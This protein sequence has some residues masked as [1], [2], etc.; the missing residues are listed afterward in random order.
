MQVFRDSTS[1]YQ[2]I[3]LDAQTSA[4]Y[5]NLK[6]VKNTI[7]R[8]DAENKRLGG[9]LYNDD[10]LNYLVEKGWFTAGQLEAAKNFRTQILN[11]RTELA[12]REVELTQQ[13][14]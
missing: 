8:L 3:L 2:E 11:A 7:K 6:G 4:E 10:E 5:D 13:K 14:R 12:S 1:K 9:A